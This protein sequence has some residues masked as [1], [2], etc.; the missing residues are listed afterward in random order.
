MAKIKGTN[1]GYGTP[2]KSTNPKLVHRTMWVSDAICK[3]EMSVKDFIINEIE[4]CMTSDP[5][6]PKD[7]FLK[8]SIV[9]SIANHFK[10]I[11]IHN[12]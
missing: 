4:K 2:M 12:G 5:E 6:N 11:L 9:K 7:E 1:T 8:N 3:P 10:K